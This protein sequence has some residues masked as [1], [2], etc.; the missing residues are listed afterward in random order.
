[1][2]RDADNHAA[3]QDDSGSVEQSRL[4]RLLGYQIT[5]AQLQVHRKLVEH[6]QT[7]SLR[8][9]EY[10]ILVLID[11][12]HGINQ[13]QIGDTLGISP[14]NLVGVINRLIKKRLMRRVRSRLDRRVQHLHLTA[15]GA[16]LLVE[17]DAIVGQFEQSL[18][19]AIGG[20]GHKQLERAL[21]RIQQL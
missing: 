6:L 9:V 21:R 11:S 16:R 2:P 18:L 3:G 13:R 19:S 7:V 12:N 15:E 5:R 8:P 10:S 14:P 17:A 4:Q 1:M 20:T